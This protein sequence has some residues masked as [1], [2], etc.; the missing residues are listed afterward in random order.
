MVRSV[1]SGSSCSTQTELFEFCSSLTRVSEPL[2]VP[3]AGQ[4]VLVVYGPPSGL[5]DHSSS[6]FQLAHGQHLF[7]RS[8]PF[9]MP[10]EIKSSRKTAEEQ[11]KSRTRVQHWVQTKQ[12]SYHMLLQLF[13]FRDLQS[14]EESS[15]V[16]ETEPSGRFVKLQSERSR[17]P[18]R[19]FT[20]VSRTS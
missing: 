19:L 4:E 11:R 13:M 10:A 8:E 12:A 9:E 18:V 17:P 15:A 5:L 2:T 16:L 3:A 14:Q 20:S 6:L 7:P 1:P